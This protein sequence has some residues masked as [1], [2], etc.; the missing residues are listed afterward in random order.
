[1]RG[2][3][4]RLFG[5]V[6]PG[7]RVVAV[8]AALRGRSPV[9]WRRTKVCRHRLRMAGAGRRLFALVLGL[10]LSGAFGLVASPTAFA[11]SFTYN[12]RPPKPVTQRPVSDNQ[13]Q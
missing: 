1:M 11:Q 8:I 6:V 2:R 5:L 4:H 10:L 12:P 9:L 7:G 3:P 13:M